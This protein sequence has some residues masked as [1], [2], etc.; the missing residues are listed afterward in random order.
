MTN[1]IT[2]AA[3]AELPGIRHAFFTREGGVSTGI[4]A[5]LN[6][7][8]GSDDRRGH[9]HANRGRVAAEI[10]ALDER[11]ATPY[12]IHSAEAVIVKEVWEPGRGPKADAV[13]TDRPGIAL[14]VGSA[15]CGPTLFA[16]PEA[17]I[18]A[19]AHSGWRGALAGVLETTV[20][21][22]ERLGARPERTVA[23]LGPTISQ[24]NYEVGPELKARFVD[25]D[26]ANAEFFLP[27]RRADHSLF[28]L[29]G[30]IV[31]RL[32]R[33]G[34]TARSVGL[35]TYADRRRF[36]SYRRATHAGEPDYGRMIS[37]IMLAD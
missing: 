35:C 7:G 24:P 2:H 21:T 25:A 19:A 20:A 28:D 4:Y 12:Q 36:F 30:F 32:V 29:P 1:K 8:V 11:L 23:V 15:D 5:S 9:V 6:C 31:S 27:A 13:V 18:V 33:T 10:G 17:G 26:P 16:D 14:G 3:L 22:M 37:V 34:V